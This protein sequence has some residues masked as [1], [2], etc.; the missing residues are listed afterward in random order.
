MQQNSAAQPANVPVLGDKAVVFM[1]KSTCHDWSYLVGY[2]AY[3]KGGAAQL[4]D[5][6]QQVIKACWEHAAL[7]VKVLVCDGGTDN[8]S[9]LKA[10]AASVPPGVELPERLPDRAMSPLLWNKYVQEPMYAISDPSHIIKKLRNALLKSWFVDFAQLPELL[11]DKP[12]RHM[13]KGGQLFSW[14]AIQLLWDDEQHRQVPGQQNLTY[15]HIYPDSF[16][17]MRVGLATDIF[18][19]LTVANLNDL[20]QR[21]QDQLLQQ[22]QQ[23]QQQQLQ[24]Q[25]PPPQLQTGQPPQ[26]QHVPGWQEL[27]RRVRVLQGTACYIAKCRELVDAVLSGEYADPA[28]AATRAAGPVQ[29]GEAVFTWL[30]EWLRSC[31]S[32]VS[33]QFIPITTFEDVSL[34][35]KGFKWYAAEFK[36]ASGV[37]IGGL[38]WRR[39]STDDLESF[40]G[41]MRQGGGS[42]RNPTQATLGNLIANA[43]LGRDVANAVRVGRSNVARGSCAAAELLCPPQDG[44]H[45]SGDTA[46]PHSVMYQQPQ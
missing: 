37:G 33:S 19:E 35:V 42:N 16:E 12:A 6:T 40:F 21:L 39:F 8:R 25:L 27:E 10:L 17:K 4:T 24:Q 3:K 46:R 44:V 36:E 28:L 5:R 9:M 38:R 13:H 18:S 7:K 1:V 34:M 20:C 41:S 30:A 22:Q 43:S 2:W 15:A 26:Q 23:Q 11:K 31:G 29:K 32:N 45:P 14:E